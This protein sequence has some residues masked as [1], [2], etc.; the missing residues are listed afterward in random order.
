MAIL[1]HRHTPRCTHTYIYPLSIGILEENMD[2]DEYIELKIEEAQ[3]AKH[4]C[5]AEDIG[6]E[7]VCQHCQEGYVV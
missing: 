4:G 5:Y 2:L 7:C 1:R 6:D 3:I